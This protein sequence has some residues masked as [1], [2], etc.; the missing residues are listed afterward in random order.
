MAILALSRIVMGTFLSRIT[1]GGMGA[2]YPTPPVSMLI[3]D[4]FV[5]QSVREPK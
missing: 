2:G 4:S 5:S 3:D 1:P